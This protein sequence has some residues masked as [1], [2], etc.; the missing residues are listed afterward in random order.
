MDRVV[1][2]DIV[3]PA[4]ERI[5]LG[6]QCQ[7]MLTGEKESRPAQ[8][9]AGAVGAAVGWDQ[10]LHGQ[11]VE[12]GPLDP[13][14][15][16]IGHHAKATRRKQTLEAPPPTLDVVLV[17]DLV[18]PQVLGRPAGRTALHGERCSPAVFARA[19]QVRRGTI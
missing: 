19:D 15:S 12:G 4:D 6:G 8:V 10:W 11:L 1:H 9:L 3:I 16:E 5:S 17:V 2:R 18:E 14:W 13:G 7:E